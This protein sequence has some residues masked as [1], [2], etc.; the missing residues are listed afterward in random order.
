MEGGEARMDGANLKSPQEPRIW[1]D[2]YP[3]AEIRKEITEAVID[4]FASRGMT[5]DECYKALEDTNN[6]LQYRARFVA[7]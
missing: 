5:Y 6:A 7:L 1:S 4:L 3:E 2:K